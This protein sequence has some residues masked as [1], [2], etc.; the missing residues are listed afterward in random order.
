[1]AEPPPVPSEL[2]HWHPVLAAS[3]LAARPR[4]VTLHGLDL[5]LFRTTSGV[6]ALGDTCPHR[7]ARLSDGHVAGDHIVCAYHGFRF[8]ADGCGA[9]PGTPRMH[10]AATR[11]DAREA[12]GAIWVRASDGD[13]VPLP[14]A[15]RPGFRH[16]GTL[17]HDID[18]PLEPLVDNFCEVEHTPTT[19]AL[20]GYRQD[21]LPDVEV[22]VETTADTVRVVNRGPQKPL[23]RLIERAFG[24]RSSDIFVDDWTVRFSPVHIVY[25]QYWLD[26]A[27]GVER[28]DR[29][30]LGV[31][32]TP[33]DRDET[34]LVTIVTTN[35]PDS[36][37]DTM[38]KPLLRALVDRE[39]RLDQRQVERLADRSPDLRG[40][41]LG[42]FDAALREHRKRIEAIYRGRPPG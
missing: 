20:F 5:V 4:P 32:F 33:I 18:C 1:M 21:A 28:G 9:S 24:I 19:H 2:R 10:L 11:F 34:R 31:F 40:T 29:L 17:V 15:R 27:T 35:R 14:F 6:A 12:W 36:L 41:R 8:A 26:P 25:D 3:D 37:F 30:H 16:F 39:V 13:D 38:V 7:R 23:P 42:R 22:T